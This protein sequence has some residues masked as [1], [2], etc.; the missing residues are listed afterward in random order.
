LRW[1]EVVTYLTKQEQ[2]V[3]WLVLALLL[4]GLAVKTYRAKHPPRVAHPPGVEEPART[5]RAVGG[6]GT[7]ANAGF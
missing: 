4:T 6:H 7:Y 3:L 1:L 2:I 5:L